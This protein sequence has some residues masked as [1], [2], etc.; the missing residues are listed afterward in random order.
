MKGLH[1][2]LFFI[3]IK[4]KSEEDFWFHLKRQKT[5][6]MFSACFYSERHRVPQAGRPAPPSSFPGRDTPPLSVKSPHPWTL[7]GSTCALL[8]HIHFMHLWAERVLGS[9]LL[10]FMM[11]WFMKG[12]LGMLRFQIVGKPGLGT[13]GAAICP[14]HLPHPPWVRS[15]CYF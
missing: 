4:K 14:L 15:P 3:I 13:G 8:V 5:E 1:R 7:C 2:H 10:W 9:L 12:F 6:T 11:F